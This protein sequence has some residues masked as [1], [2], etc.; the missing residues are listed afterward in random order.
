MLSPSFRAEKHR[1]R[2]HLT[3]FWHL[4]AE[5]L[6]ST[7]DDIM[8]VE[9]RL[10]HAIVQYI[11]RNSPRQLDLLKV[12]VSVPK[13]PFKRITYDDALEIA[14][15]Q[16]FKTSWG[17]DL[18]TQVERAIS[19]EFK[20]PFFI[21]GYPTVSRSFYHMPDPERPEVTLSSDL[22]A[23][24]GYG[25]LTSGG[26]RIH[27]LDQLLARI[28][29]QKLDPSQYDWYLEL[30]KFGLPPHAGFGMGLERVLVWLLGLKHIRQATLFPRTPSRIQP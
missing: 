20:E 28:A 17:D 19:K 21:T 29:E 8:G 25:E 30:R 27:D 9:E 26:Q 1:T 6:F 5:I 13:L 10:V 11:K 18:G 7:H 22:M 15:Q 3:E 24:G 16:G 12:K 4:E 14:A 2:K 23:P